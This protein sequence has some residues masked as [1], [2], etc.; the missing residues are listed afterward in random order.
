M[1]RRTKNI[2]KTQCCLLISA[3]VCVLCCCSEDPGYRPKDGSNNIV[4]RVRKLLQE[5]EYIAVSRGKYVDADYPT[6]VRSHVHDITKSGAKHA[7]SYFPQQV[8]GSKIQRERIYRKTKFKVKHEMPP[9]LVIEAYKHA[10]V[11][12]TSKSKDLSHLDSRVSGRYHIFH[13]EDSCFVV[14][15]Q[16]QVNSQCLLWKRTGVASQ[17]IAACMFAYIKE[18]SPYKG[19]EFVYTKEAC[20]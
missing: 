19:H 11:T 18:C 13:A 4:K 15:T 3:Y 17:E 2:M 6:C 12:S 5:K 7:L 9:L 14:G 8:K 20:K 16:Q 1:L 10:L